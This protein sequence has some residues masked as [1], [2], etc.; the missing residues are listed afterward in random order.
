MATLP[1][2]PYDGT[3]DSGNIQNMVRGVQSADIITGGQQL[4]SDDTVTIDVQGNDDVILFILDTGG[5]AVV[6]IAAGDNPPSPR[7]G[8]GAEAYT[9]PDADGVLIFPEAGRH[10]KNTG[11]IHLTSTQQVLVWAFRAPAGFIGVGQVNQTTVPSA[12]T[13]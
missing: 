2:T 8:L 7:A 10:V 3:T 1:I 4:D 6:S 13:D 5:G 9:I 12:P 11:K